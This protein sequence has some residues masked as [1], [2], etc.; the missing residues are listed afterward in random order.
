MF[1]FLTT[2]L[3]LMSSCSWVEYDWFADVW[4]L[5][6]GYSRCCERQSAAERYSADK[7]WRAD[8][9]ISF[10]WW[11]NHTIRWYLTISGQ[12]QNLP[13]SVCDQSWESGACSSR[14]TTA[15]T[16]IHARACTHIKL[17]SLTFLVSRKHRALKP[18]CQ[19]PATPFASSK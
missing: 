15:F 10:E 17:G 9:F 14:E 13:S 6:H 3:E 11:L 8:R 19:R 12:H 16:D 7:K 18:S 4:D 2:V 5:P 1:F